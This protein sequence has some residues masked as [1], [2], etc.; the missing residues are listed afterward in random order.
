MVGEEDYVSLE[1]A[2]LLKDK[3][4]NVPCLYQYTDKGTV[5]RCFDP[6][7]F[8]ASETCYS[9]PTLYEVQKWLRDTICIHIEIGY[10]YGN[11]WIYDLLTIPTHD[12]IGLTDRDNV[13]Y[14]SYEEALSAGILEVLELI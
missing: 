6:E 8:N 3:G 9:C 10:M 14:E 12:L 1:M 11:Y 2:K 7:N 4:F 13:K 5:W